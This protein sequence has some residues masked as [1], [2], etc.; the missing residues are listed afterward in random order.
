[1]DAKLIL[2]EIAEIVGVKLHSEDKPVEQPV[3]QT[4]ELADAAPAVQP[5]TEVE[6]PEQETKEDATVVDLQNRVVALEQ[7]LQQLMTEMQMSKDN[8]VKLSKIVET[9][10]NTPVSEPIQR[11]ETLELSK[12]NKE[13]EQYKMFVRKIK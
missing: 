1:M 11:T 4:V 2:K 10:A 12:D 5:A 7:A 8:A 6:T 9:I 13:D 3:E